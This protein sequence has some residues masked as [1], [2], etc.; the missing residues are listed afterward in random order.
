M[1]AHP[2]LAFT[3]PADASSPAFLAQLQALQ[4]EA[5]RDFHSRLLKSEL[6]LIGIRTPLL[7][8]IAKQIAKEN[9]IAFLEHSPCR[10]YEERVLYG[11]VLCA[12]KLPYAE[13]LP[14]CTHYITHLVENW[15]LCDLFCGEVKKMP[16]LQ[17]DDFFSYL[18]AHW[19]YSE[20]PWEVRT[21]LVLL[22]EVYLQEAYIDD[23]LRLIGTV[24]PNGA[25]YVEM[26]Q[27][28]LLSVAFVKFREKTLAFLL[29]DTR[30]E[31]SVLQKTVQK[32][33]DSYRISQED[34]TMLSSLFK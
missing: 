27:A 5:Y 1:P 17:K 33:R 20:N 15:A 13:F 23:V 30:P 21:A 2:T 31:R 32:C 34:K 24:R 3:F 11:M 12:L 26:A 29:G 4:D 6:P 7:R 14:Y 25:Y 28:W 18:Q 8:K 19:L 10:Y 22:L 16:T 9:G